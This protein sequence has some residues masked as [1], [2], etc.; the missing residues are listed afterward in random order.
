MRI[1]GG[2]AKGRRIH[3]P[4][5]SKI[6]PTS[7]G[8]KESLFNILPEV[9]E[10]SFLDL[11]AGTGNVGIEALSRGASKVVF[12]EKNAVMANSIKRN[13]EEFGLSGKYEIL[14]TEASKGIRQLQ[15]RRERFDYLFADPPYEK[16]FIR[17][18]FQCIRE[19]EM[20]SSDGFV[21]IQHSIRENIE[22]T[23]TG[24]FVLT[25]Q[26][27][28]GDTLLSFFNNTVK[29]KGTHI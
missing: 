25:D 28:Y 24:T 7:D 9:S 4:K 6:R 15:K 8:I 10:K 22:G 11:F 3:S 21:V 2:D 29:E 16:G 26:R 18:I 17:E 20:I 1:I 19:G 27:K 13:L 12:I 14:T 23:Q 5:R